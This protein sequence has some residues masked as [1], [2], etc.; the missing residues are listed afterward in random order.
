M[1]NTKWLWAMAL[2]AIVACKKDER[3]P[4]DSYNPVIDVANFTQSTTLTNPYLLYP[5]DKKYVYEGQTADGLEH[6][7]VQRTASTRII[8]GI[9]CIVVNDKVWVGG[10]LAEDTDDWYAQDNSGNVWYLGEDVDNFNPDGSLKDHHGAWEAGVD[11]A[12]P[13]I[14]MLAGPQTG[15]TYRQEYYFNEAEDQAKVIATGLTL[16][17]PFGTFTDCIQIEEWTELEPD[18]RE[19]KFYAPG[20]GLIKEV[21]VT[22]N[23]EIVLKEIQE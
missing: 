11:G 15:Q 14:V 10:Q 1:K 23:E 5:P 9:T 18:V 8:L 16:S 19:H 4:D 12:K 21:N 22:D 2:L 13:G 3:Q 17:I 6:I 7:E 20:I